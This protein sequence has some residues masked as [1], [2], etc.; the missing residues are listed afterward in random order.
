MSGSES[1]SFRTPRRVVLVCEDCGKRTVL[2]EPLAVRC[3][4]STRIACAC[5]RDLTLADRLDQQR[6]SGAHGTTSVPA[7]PSTIYR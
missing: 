7:L 1:D 2:D 5:G 3:S 6:L 4:R